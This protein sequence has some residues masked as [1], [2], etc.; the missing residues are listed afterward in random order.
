MS[1]GEV[2]DDASGVAEPSTHVGNL[3]DRVVEWLENPV[4][5]GQLIYAGL[6]VVIVLLALWLLGGWW[7][8]RPGYYA[9][10]KRRGAKVAPRRGRGS[11]RARASTAGRDSSV[12]GPMPSS[13]TPTSSS[14]AGEEVLPM[15]SPRTR[16][17]IKVLQALRGQTGRSR[18]LELP[19]RLFDL[20]RA[21][22][23]HAAGS[24]QDLRPFAGEVDR[25]LNFEVRVHPVPNSDGVALQFLHQGV[26]VADAQGPYRGEIAHRFIEMAEDLQGELRAWLDSVRLLLPASAVDS[27]SVPSYDAPW[28]SPAHAT[29]D[30]RRHETS[31]DSI[32]LSGIR[33]EESSRSDPIREAFG[34]GALG[35]AQPSRHRPDP[36]PAQPELATEVAFVPEPEPVVEAKPRPSSRGLPQRLGRALDEIDHVR[37]ELDAEPPAT[38]QARERFFKTETLERT[39]LLD[40]LDRFVFTAFGIDS[41][42]V[43]DQS[44]PKVA[45]ALEWL[46]EEQD[47]LIE[48]LWQQFGV[49]EHHAQIGEPFE[50]THHEGTDTEPTDDPSQ[51]RTVAR[52]ASHG[53]TLALGKELRFLLRPK[54]TIYV[55]ESESGSEAGSGVSQAPRSRRAVAVAE[56]TMDVPVDS[57][58]TGERDFS[59]TVYAGWRVGNDLQAWIEV[60]G[61]RLTFARAEVVET[62][63]SQSTVRLSGCDIPAGIRRGD[64]ALVLEDG[65][66]GRAARH[67]FEV[68][69]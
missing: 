58:Y 39:S 34:Y 5:Q 6:G 41:I 11:A 54:V 63:A 2:T 45:Y 40:R 30:A 23:Q 17:Y 57:A 8:S 15:M 66:N 48:V 52:T 7:R 14:A 68:I 51:D 47:R 55:Y 35:R 37:D 31:I 9:R 28:P 20:A 3:M 61:Q 69:T 4:V 56:D 22:D 10:R 25:L 44:D 27:A 33:T 12:A 65:S 36:E 43:P 42:P 1:Y 32:D 53:Y 62:S 24:L 59:L 50:P 49:Q 18:G 46:H 13:S 67:P 64:G 38:I 26:V 29:V 16:S 21:L 19:K 60:D